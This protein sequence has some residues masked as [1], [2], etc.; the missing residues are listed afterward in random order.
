MSPPDVPYESVRL[1]AK[2]PIDINND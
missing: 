2:F 1:P